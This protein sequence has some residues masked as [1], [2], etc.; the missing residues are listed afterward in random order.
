MP[1]R[2]GSCRQRS[3]RHT[4]VAGL[5]RDSSC[6]CEASSRRQAALTGAGGVPLSLRKRTKP[7][8]PPRGSAAQLPPPRSS[9]R[10]ARPPAQPS[11]RQRRT[12]RVRSTS[13]LR[14][15]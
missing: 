13:T 14:R 7:G 6:A 9:R 4:D 2:P 15:R 10:G 3:V 5:P 1:S 8:L 11:P 12:G